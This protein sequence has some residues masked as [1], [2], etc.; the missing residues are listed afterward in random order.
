MNARIVFL[1]LLLV[2]PHTLF[3]GFIVQTITNN[4]ST[5][6]MIIRSEHIPGMEQSTEYEDWRGAIIPVK[7][8][9]KPFVLT[10][11]IS[12]GVDLRVLVVEGNCGGKKSKKGMSCKKYWIHFDEDAQVI[13]RYKK[14]KCEKVR[15][16]TGGEYVLLESKH[17]GSENSVIDIILDG[18]TQELHFLV[19]S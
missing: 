16:E 15:G 10:A 14:D 5:N 7:T 4:S 11:N 18:K 9:N 8:K 2:S 6:C 12:G 13:E 1:L 17:V 3:S 19:V